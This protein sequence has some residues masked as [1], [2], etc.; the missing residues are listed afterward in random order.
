VVCVGTTAAGGLFAY[1]G[2]YESTWD[3]HVIKVALFRPWTM[4][5][6]AHFSIYPNMRPFLAVARTVSGWTT[7]TG[8][9]YLLF[10]GRSR[11]LLVEVPVVVALAAILVPADAHLVRTPFRR[12]RPSEGSARPDVPTS[13]HPDTVPVRRIRLGATLRASQA[14]G[15]TRGRHHPWRGRRVGS[16][17]RRW[18]EARLR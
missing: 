1:G 13:A 9:D 5:V 4:D 3:P 10:Q 16:D 12:S 11:Y 15:G 14:S 6:V 7:G 2:A 18:R 17:L 8:V